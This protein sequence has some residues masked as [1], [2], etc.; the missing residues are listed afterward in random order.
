MADAVPSSPDS[1][2]A[3]DPSVRRRLPLVLITLASVL[4]LGAIFARWA[5]RQLLDTKNWTEGSSELLEDEAIQGRIAVF[6]ADQLYANRDVQG[7]LE[8]ALPPRA[9]PLAGPAAVGLCLRGSG[10][11]RP[12]PSSLGTDPRDASR[13]PGARPGRPARARARGPQATDRARVPR[14][15]PRGVDATSAPAA[16]GYGPA[17][18]RRNARAHPAVRASEALAGDRLEQLERL[19]KLRETGVLDASEF[20]REKA[21]ILAAAP[22]TAG[23]HG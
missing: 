10:G 18:A 2:A 3:V 22:A 21:Q 7:Q 8:Q 12:G 11:H 23:G 19:G 20:E 15:E 17:D 6:L 14:G 9:Q 5:N 4:A 16:R 13:D 1:A